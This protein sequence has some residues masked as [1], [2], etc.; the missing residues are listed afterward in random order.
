MSLFAQ[1]NN[2]PNWVRFER[3]PTDQKS[4]L[5]VKS[6]HPRA[7]KS[8]IAYSQTLRAKTVCSTGDE[9]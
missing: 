7:L 6:E 3:K 1:I 2:F 4:Y 9:Y 8:N 5:Q